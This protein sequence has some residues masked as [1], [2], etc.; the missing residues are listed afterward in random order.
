MPVVRSPVVRWLGVAGG[1][2]AQV[3]CGGAPGVV[4]APAPAAAALD[5]AAIETTVFLV[6]DAG[7]ATPADRVLAEVGRQGQLA[8][9]S[10]L[11]V[12]LGDNVY[13]RG[14]PA[15][16]A[17][18]YLEA[19]D[20][21]FVQARLAPLTGLRIIFIPGNHDWDGQGP[22]GWINVQHQGRLLKRFADST[23][24]KVELLPEAGCPGPV[25]VDIGTRLRLVAIDTHWWLH[26]HGRP[27]R[28]PPGLRAQLP[29]P[30]TRCP[31]TT[32]DA[33]VGAL[34]EIHARG[35]GRVAVLVGHHPLR[36]SGEHGGY[37]PWTRYLFPLVPTPFAPW[38]WLPLGWIE[39]LG[40]KLLGHPQD[41]AG[42]A[43]RE[44]RSAIEATFSPTAPLIYAAGHDHSLEVGR[45]G[46]DR[47]F[48]VSGSGT[49]NHQSAVG[50]GDSVAFRSA[51]PGFARVDLM[52]DGRV[53]IGF[54][55]LTDGR[56]EESYHAW[57]KER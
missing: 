16:T 44:M 17:A 53:R 13:P 20:R 9:R 11:I 56:I 12:F 15:D 24:A 43:N 4:L 47:F 5:S 39:P 27:G 46:P 28:E 26:G 37:Y 32:K 6:G 29:D 22:A 1:L 8:P 55:T 57:L 54:T 3:G 50:R 36:S 14:I 45:Q 25:P 48:L 18:S 34:R 49:E 7:H 30:D 38:L 41:F 40:R 31:V 51:S 2:L 52:R 33:V 23:G 21:L 10:S 19:R 35:D 42:R